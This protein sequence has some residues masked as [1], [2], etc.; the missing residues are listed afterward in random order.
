VNTVKESDY[1]TENMRITGV[2]EEVDVM[3]Q[4]E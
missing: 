3:R 4:S 2:S 1:P